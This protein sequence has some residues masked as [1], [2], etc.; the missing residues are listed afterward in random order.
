MRPSGETAASCGPRP[1]GSFTRTFSVAGS[2]SANWN[3][4]LQAT[5]TVSAHALG[6][7]AHTTRI[8]TSEI[9]QQVFFIVISL[10]RSKISFRT[11]ARP[12]NFTL[13]VERS[14]HFNRNP[15]RI[16]M[17]ERDRT[18]FEVPCQSRFALGQLVDGPQ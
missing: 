17:R 11:A 14:V 12:V 9:S 18:P 1:V 4:D 10:K 13:A 5:T 3:S 15:N 6:T 8:A 16:P 2:T 7:N